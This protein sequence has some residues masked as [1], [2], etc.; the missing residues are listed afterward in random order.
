MPVEGLRPLD[1]RLHRSLAG[2][3][4][5]AQLLTTFAGV[6]LALTLIGVW[7]LT[8]YAVTQRTREIGVRMALGVDRVTVVRMVLREV[9]QLAFGGTAVGL[10]AALAS[11][12]LLATL[13]FGVRP[14]DPASFAAGAIGLV[15]VAVLGG[16]VPA[17]RAARVDPVTA[18]QRE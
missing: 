10:C 14:A 6:A 5:S 4:F 15:A 13:L 11:T 1:A 12:R 7:G 9:L 8:T 2:R 17:R 18:L 3:R 16:Y